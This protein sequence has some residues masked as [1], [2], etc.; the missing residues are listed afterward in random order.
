MTT[1]T[2]ALREQF[3][4]YVN[5]EGDIKLHRLVDGN[6]GL[7]PFEIRAGL[8]PSGSSGGEAESVL[9]PLKSGLA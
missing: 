8:K 5:P 7:N 3:E 9:I 6:F 1:N 2:E 4:L